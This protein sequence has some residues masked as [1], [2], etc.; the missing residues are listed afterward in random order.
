MIK[1]LDGIESNLNSGFEEEVKKQDQDLDQDDKN[2]ED[3]KQPE[4]V[5][6][7]NLSW[8]QKKVKS[9]SEWLEAEPETELH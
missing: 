4:A 6:N 5:E 2:Q 1:G 7:E 3:D 8:F 9:V